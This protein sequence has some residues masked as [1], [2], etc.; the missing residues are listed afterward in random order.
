M[1]LCISIDEDN[2]NALYNSLIQDN[3]QDIE[4]ECTNNKLIIKII[5][6]KLS[7]I[8][9]LVDDIIRDYETYKKVGEL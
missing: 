1:E 6:V 5:N 9:N 2:C 4:M 7:S 3:N 8:Y